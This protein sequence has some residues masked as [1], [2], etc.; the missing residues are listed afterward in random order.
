MLNMLAC[1]PGEGY[2]CRAQGPRKGEDMSGD[3]QP[4][5]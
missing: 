2:R 1:A 4:F 3:L 5:A